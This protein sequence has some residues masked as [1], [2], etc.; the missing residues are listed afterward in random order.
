[1]LI[2][3]IALAVLR[4]PVAR[5]AEQAGKVAKSAE[6]GSVTHLLRVT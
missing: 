4:L 3:V 1:M 2:V 5:V 6:P